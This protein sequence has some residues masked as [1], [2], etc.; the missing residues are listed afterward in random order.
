MIIYRTTL[1]EG[2][3]LPT[4]VNA[5]GAAAAA[6]TQHGIVANEKGQLVVMIDASGG[7]IPVDT[8]GGPAGPAEIEQV[9]T[10]GVIDTYVPLPSI[11]GTF[12]TVRNPTSKAMRLARAG[13]AFGSG[14]YITISPNMSERVP[15][16]NCDEY[17]VVRHDGVATPLRLEL[18]IEG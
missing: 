8:T 1:A 10:S 15:C 4:A 13:E 9:V 18:A 2:Y 14:K 17:Q 6:R 12:V 7:A 3:S 11:A 16:V 5:G